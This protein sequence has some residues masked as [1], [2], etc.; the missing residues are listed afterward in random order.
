MFD[1]LQTEKILDG[2]AFRKTVTELLL[3]ARADD[4]MAGLWEAGD[5]Q[6]WAALDEGSGSRRDAF[7]FDAEHRP[8]AAFTSWL[9]ESDVYTEFL[10]RPSI[11]V[12]TRDQL[13]DLVVER[14]VAD[15]RFAGKR[16]WITV[17]E[18]DFLL[19]ERFDSAGFGFNPN[20]DM[21]QMLFRPASVPEAVALPERMIFTDDRS[22]NAGSPHHLAKRNGSG[23]VDKLHEQSL[24]RRDLD[25][26]IR[27]DN[28]DVAAYCLCWLDVDN[29]VGLFEPVRTE[30]AFQRMGLGHSLMIEG[31]GRL[32]H[33]GADVIKVSR[34]RTNLAA[35][36]LYSRAGFTDS[37]AKL[38]YSLFRSS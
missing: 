11:D 24:Y 22:R 20:D 3:L 2:D 21:V 36:R 25:L 19:R 6:W 30:D 10:S 26:S 27:T 38:R 8:I 5:L 37:Y 28:G 15:R 31:I 29:G 7:W 32:R 18:R 4:P 35:E 23:I 9:A 1:V 17:D 16:V 34:D 12:A 14:L 13:I 33:H